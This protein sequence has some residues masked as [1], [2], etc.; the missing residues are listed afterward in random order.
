MKVPGS[1]D[2]SNAYPASV[3]VISARRASRPSELDHPVTVANGAAGSGAALTLQAVDRIGPDQPAGRGAEAQRRRRLL[4]VVYWGGAIALVPWIAL[5]YSAQPSN[6]V[7]YHLAILRVG[8]SAFMVAGMVATAHWCSRNSHLTVLAGTFTATVAFMSAWFAI[9]TTSGARFT[10][11]LAYGLGMHLPVVVACIWTVRRH[12]QRLGTADGPPARVAVFLAVG[13]VAFVPLIVLAALGA[14][15]SHAAHHLELMWTGLDVFELLAMA[16]TGWCLW[17]RHPNLAVAA[18]LTGTLMLCDAWYDVV[19]TAGRAEGTSVALACLEITLAVLSF[20]VARTVV[21]GWPGRSRSAHRSAAS[22]RAEELHG[23]VN[24]VE[25]GR[26]GEVV[27]A[28]YPYQGGRWQGLDQ[29][30]G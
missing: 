1:I 22:P 30:V 5:L 15:S 16:L 11:A 9:V 7:V 25:V 14:P 23:G 24:D 17:R 4:L 28:R 8:A 27:H 20:A 3:A 29:V 19:T 13:A 26:R 6:A 21:L 2:A 10:V 18:A 12:L